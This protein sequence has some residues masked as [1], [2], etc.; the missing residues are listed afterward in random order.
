MEPGYLLIFVAR[1]SRSL[2]SRGASGAGSRSP[3][4]LSGVQ[5]AAGRCVSPAIHQPPPRPPLRARCAARSHDPTIVTPTAPCPDQCRPAVCQ[6]LVAKLSGNLGGGSLRWLRK[7]GVGRAISTAFSPARI[8]AIFHLKSGVFPPPTNSYMGRRVTVGEWSGRSAAAVL[9]AGHP[10]S[11][12]TIRRT[13]RAVCLVRQRCPPSS[14]AA[15][16]PATITTLVGDSL[17][18]PLGKRRQQPS[19]RSQ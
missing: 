12:Q 7:H 13:S 6:A 9:G 14:R 10:L 19:E 5:L 17:R 4:G 1:S 15:V 11:Y 3:R 8:H 16:E 2:L 18:S